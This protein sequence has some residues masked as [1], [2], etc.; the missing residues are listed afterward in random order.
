MSVTPRPGELLTPHQ[1]DVLLG[2]FAAGSGLAVH[3]VL[4]VP[5]GYPPL[6]R[7]PAAGRFPAGLRPDFAGHP[8]F[9]IDDDTRRRR[10]G[11]PD[12]V[13]TVR[14]WIELVDR[15]LVHPD[16]G[17]WVDVVAH[18][19]GIDD[20]TTLDWLAEFAAGGD[21]PEGIGVLEF[22]PVA[23]D[24]R[25]DGWALAVAERNTEAHRRAAS[26][27]AA[28]L[29]ARDDL[30]HQTA[31]DAVTNPRPVSELAAAVADAADGELAAA[32]IDAHA[33]IIHLEM[34]ARHLEVEAARRAGGPAAAGEVSLRLVAVNEAD[35]AGRRAELDQL[36]AETRDTGDRVWLVAWVERCCTAAIEDAQ[37]TWSALSDRFSAAGAVDDWRWAT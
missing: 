4:F 20:V 12:D 22:G 5:W 18:L 25:P 17:E 6:P 10:A 3:E 29:A 11:E 1:A 9:W 2:E 27:E 26:A 28:A 16:N 34:A 31:V 13:W 24:G 35:A 30:L 36:L 32:V 7:P 8:V 33:A 21:D 37:R 19:T 15:G 23:H 14:L